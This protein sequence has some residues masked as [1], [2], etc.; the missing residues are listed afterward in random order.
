MHLKEF[1]QDTKYNNENELIQNTNSERNT[2]YVRIQLTV[3]EISDIKYVQRKLPAMKSL[4][5]SV[6]IVTDRK[7]S[8]TINRLYSERPV[9]I[10]AT[11]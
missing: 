8:F 10:V 2:I 5:S 4:Y 6:L 1:A 11:S 9:F 7:Q 3:R